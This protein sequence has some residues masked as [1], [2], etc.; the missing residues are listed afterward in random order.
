M[1]TL[2]HPGIPKGQPSPSPQSSRNR[3]RKWE[4]VSWL[5]PSNARGQVTPSADSV[6][7]GAVVT[8]SGGVA[9]PIVRPGARAEPPSECR[10]KT[11]LKSSLRECKLNRTSDTMF[12]H[13]FPERI[14]ARPWPPE[15]DS[16]FS[17]PLLSF[18]QGL[19]LSSEGGFF[20]APLTCSFREKRLE[21]VVPVHRLFWRLMSSL[22][23]ST[24]PLSHTRS[25]HN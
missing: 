4:P 6:E 17:G 24:H 11:G 9:I 1:C 25:L 16:L 20:P 7:E 10:A 15:R 8:C 2:P 19:P 21:K 18:S 12:R 3:N 13:I 22:T 14:N 23:H 5:P